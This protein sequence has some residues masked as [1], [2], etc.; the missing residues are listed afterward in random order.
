MALSGFPEPY[1]EG[2]I[3]SEGRSTADVAGVPSAVVEGVAD[4]VF[5]PAPLAA[6]DLV[7]ADA[8]SERE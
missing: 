1:T 2:A 8:M 5:L 4:L 6:A 3:C 7:F